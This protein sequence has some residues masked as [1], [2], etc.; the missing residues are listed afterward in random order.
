MGVNNPSTFHKKDSADSHSDAKRKKRMATRSL[1]RHIDETVQKWVDDVQAI[2]PKAKIVPVC[3]FD[4]MFDDAEAQRRCLALRK[5]LEKHELKYVKV[6]PNYEKPLKL[7]SIRR[8]SCIAHTGL[9]ELMDDITDI[10][11][12]IRDMNGFFLAAQRNALRAPTLSSFIR[13][14]NNTV[15]RYSSA[16]ENEVIAIKELSHI[17]DKL[18]SNERLTKAAASYLSS[19]GNV[20]YYGNSFVENNVSIF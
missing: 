3:T 1:D 4:D 9:T 11:D 20:S 19:I 10:S 18:D 8:I 17:N 14:V 16:K 5:R 6:N 13:R 12:K 7:T 2:G 15:K